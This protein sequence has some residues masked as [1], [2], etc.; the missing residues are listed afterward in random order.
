MI[1]PSLREPAS[2]GEVVFFAFAGFLLVAFVAG[3]LADMRHARRKG[4]AD[5]EEDEQ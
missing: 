4:D 3:Y 2:A 5:R 1:A